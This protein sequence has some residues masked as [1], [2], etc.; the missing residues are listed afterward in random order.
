M[1][2]S[3]SSGPIFIETFP[4]TILRTLYLSSD[5]I[6]SRILTDER[7]YNPHSIEEKHIEQRSNLPLVKQ[8]ITFEDEV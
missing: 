6:F 1:E 2:Y 5:L 3:R 8:L 7:Y 4:A